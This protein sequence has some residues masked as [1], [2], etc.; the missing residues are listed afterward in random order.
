MTQR[1]R[2]TAAAGDRYAAILKATAEEL[3]I[4][5]SSDRCKQIALLRLLRDNMTTAAMLRQ[6]V[7]IADVRELDAMY[8]AHI[9][10]VE[11]LQINVNY[12]EGVTGIY[13]CKHCG[14]RNDLE[15]GS[16]TPIPD[17]PAP[18]PAPVPEPAPVAAKPADNVVDITRNLHYG[19]EGG[20][21]MGAVYCP[22]AGNTAADLWRNDP[23]PTRR[24]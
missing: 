21:N 22:A 10:E 15:H 23:S 17:R 7:P 12:V 5:A 3:G 4:D 18:A 20:G 14:Q 13:T 19:S 6:R 16:Y 24:Y 9:P 8:K 1:R 11:G 2:V